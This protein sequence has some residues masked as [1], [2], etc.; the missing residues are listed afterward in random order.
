MGSAGVPSGRSTSSH[1]AHV[2][3]DGDPNRYNGLGVLT[4]VQSINEI[5]GPK[6][7]GCKGN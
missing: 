3:I 5:I 2:L 1:E 4:A 6:L 7:V